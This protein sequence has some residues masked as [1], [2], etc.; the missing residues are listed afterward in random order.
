M[1]IS[2]KGLSLIKNA[3]G[4]KLKAYKCPAGVWTI[5]YG[6]TKIA[7]EGMAITKEFADSLL[8]NDVQGAEN[9]VN[10]TGLTFTQNQ[11]DALVSFVYNIGCG[12]FTKSTLLNKIRENATPDQIKSEFRRWI[13][14]GGKVLKGLADRREKEIDLFFSK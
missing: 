12:A 4:L 1:K 14:A 5:G 2:D 6:H 11:F 7:Y 8:R 13:Y 9:C 10:N 3:E